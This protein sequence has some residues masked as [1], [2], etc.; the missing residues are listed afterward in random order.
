M[1]VRIITLSENTVGAFG[2]LAEWGLSILVEAGSLKVLMDTGLSISVPHN[3]PRLGVDLATVDKIVLSHGHADHTGGLRDVL[4]KTG[5][6]EVIAHPDMWAAKYMRF[7]EVDVYIGIPFSREE[8]EALGASFT[9]SREPVWITDDIVTTGEIPM[10]TQYEQ[11]DPNLYVKVDEE[12]VPD[13][14]LDD[15]ALIIKT[16]VGLVVILGC[17]HRGI[18]NTLHHAREL[19]GV[20]LVHTVIGGTHLVSASEERVRLTAAAL[21]EF[22]IQRLGV[23]HCTG[24]PAAMMLA[25]EFGDAFFFNNAG[26]RITVP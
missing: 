17:G 21:R 20:E 16:D 24:M 19:T 4:T 3:A 1:Q 25:Q 11:I 5:K 15:R 7:G 9:L 14:L 18:I 10:I 12:F 2:V 6:V 26:T 23:S 13:P 8:L 22:G